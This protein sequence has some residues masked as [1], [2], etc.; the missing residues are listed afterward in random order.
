MRY[1]PLY[2]A[3]V[4]VDFAHP[5]SDLSPYNLVIAPNLYLVTDDSVESF[6]SGI[7]DR[8]DNI[9]LGGYPAPFIELLGLRVEDFVPMATGQK[10][11]LDTLDSESY[12]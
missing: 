7:V 2:E 5:G 8:R 11:R 4:P 1:K 10:N 9:R 12:G 3:N 6:F